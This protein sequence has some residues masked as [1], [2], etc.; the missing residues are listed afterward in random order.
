MMNR[1]YTNKNEHN[2]L[3]LP[4]KSDVYKKKLSNFNENNFQEDDYESDE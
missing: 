1:N 2:D 4:S 3:D